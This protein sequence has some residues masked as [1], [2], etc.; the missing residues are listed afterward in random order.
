MD[1]FDLEKYEQKFH[2]WMQFKEVYDT[3]LDIKLTLDGKASERPKLELSSLSNLLCCSHWL[4]T[5]VTLPVLLLQSRAR[6]T[7][8]ESRVWRPTPRSCR[9]T[10]AP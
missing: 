10:R 4:F 1:D 7:I 3:T 2:D 6:S 8:S 9:G 5:Y